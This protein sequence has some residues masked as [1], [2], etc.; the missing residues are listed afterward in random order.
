LFDDGFLPEAHLGFGGFVAVFLQLPVQ[1]S[2]GIGGDWERYRYDSANNGDDPTGPP[3]YKDETLDY[4]RL[5]GLVQYD[6]LPQSVLNPFVFGLAGYQWERH[7]LTRWQCRPKQASG[8]MFGGGLGVEYA[9]SELARVGVEYR[10]A[11][12]PDS[13]ATCTLA[14]IPDEP[15]GAPYDFSPMRIALTLSAR[16]L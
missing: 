6:M 7:E 12:Q 10:Y 1:L 5:L 15:R 9:V 8:V 16:G 3:R 14:F 13:T 11:T 2:A 4:T